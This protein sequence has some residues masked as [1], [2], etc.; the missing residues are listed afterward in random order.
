MVAGR[1]TAWKIQKKLGEGDA[2]EVY[3]VESL[4]EG[5]AAVLKRPNPGAFPS[6][7]TRQ[8]AQIETEGKILRALENLGLETAAGR[9]RAPALLDVSKS[10]TEFSERYFI[11]IDQAP[12]FDLNALARAVTMGPPETAETSSTS[13][14]PGQVLFAQLVARGLVPRL[15]LLR[16][17]WLMLAFIQEAHRRMLNDEGLMHHGAIWNDIKP[18]HLF[19]DPLQANLTLIDWGNGKF[20]QKDGTTKDRQSS[21]T[22]DARQFIHEMG[23][24]LQNFRPDLHEELTWPDGAEGVE[25]PVQVLERVQERIE[26][27]GTQELEKLAQLR[28]RERDLCETS[29]P[30]LAALQELNDLQEQILQTGELPN[31]AG[32]ETLALGLSTGLASQGRWEQFA[33]VCS[34]AARLPVAT[35]EKWRLLEEISQIGSQV[36]AQ[37]L[38]GVTQALVA[39][40]VD[41]WPSALWSLAEVYQTQPQPTWWTEL[42]QRMRQL[43]YQI[44][45][46]LLPPFMALNR[47]YYLVQAQLKKLEPAQSASESTIGE[48]A[49]TLERY[50]LLGKILQEEILAKWTLVEPEPPD[51]SLEYRA[52]EN[53]LEDLGSLIPNANVAMRKTLDQPTT[54]IQIVLDAWGRKEYDTARKGLRRILLW[55]PH[56]WRVLAAERFI[57]KAPIWQEKVRSGPPDGELLA[58]FMARLELEGRELRNRVGPAHWLDI[59]LNTLQRLRKGT[60]AGDLISGNPDL[61]GLMPWISRVGWVPSQPTA[62]AKPV[63]LTRE[64]IPQNHRSTIDEVKASRLG[65]SQGFLLGDPLDTWAPEARGS[66][67]R[68]FLGF[69]RNADGNLK[70]T[71]V[72]VMRRDRVEYALPLFEEEI[73]VLTAMQDVAGVTPI[74]ETGYIKL[75]RGVELPP[76]TTPISARDLRGE[77]MRYSLQY[78]DEFQ[79]Q[80]QARIGKGWMP[81]LALEKRNPEDNLMLLCDAGYTRGRFISLVEALRIAIQICDILQAAH[82][83][84]ILYR[85]HKILHFYWQEQYNG[86]FIIDWNVAKHH[87]QGLTD[88]EKQFDLV[89]FGARA[90][91]H[92]FTGRPAPGALP[93][94]P[95]R[96]EEID[97]AAH[98]YTVQWTYDDRRLP[99]ELKELLERVLAGDY[100]EIE[101]L[102]RDLVHAFSQLQG[103]EQEQTAD[104]EP[105]GNA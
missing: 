15:L 84:H 34:Q 19:W 45:A 53:I 22:D 23:R 13:N 69:L 11:V 86:V 54:Q 99:Y 51:S 90:L 36:E 32:T 20:L 9:V 100:I 17:L 16:V 101:N 21:V 92:I 35:G 77:V 102:R 41:D 56:R 24:F 52:L 27:L 97:T 38:P 74:L 46:S 18:D 10:G 44:D 47:I 95:T 6:E 89:Q 4:L 70:Q 68:V 2:G 40:L 39:G 26:A 88:E 37:Y 31:Y 28:Q 63:R 42:S 12:G 85:D 57:R 29:T 71:A 33:E 96:P 83:R 66:S 65:Q 3:L 61:L 93:M 104:T 67:A 49:E 91:H 75:D 43:H 8:A 98:S 64:V 30:T 79:E 62:P 25:G 80:M 48:P 94:G 73:K 59:I 58:D 14:L 1:S 82:E 103:G 60:R 81:Y 105:S 7:I 55:D 5:R 87:P 78:L 72:K 50:Q 76:E